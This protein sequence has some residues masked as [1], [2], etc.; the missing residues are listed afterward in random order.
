MRLDPG[1][2]MEAKDFLGK[3]LTNQLVIKTLEVS[4]PKDTEWPVSLIPALKNIEEVILWGDI[5]D[6]VKRKLLETIVDADRASLK[7]R[8][9]RGLSTLNMDEK[10][11]A[12]AAIRLEALDA[13]WIF[14]CDQ[15]RPEGKPKKN[16][17]LTFMN[18]GN[19]KY[20][21][22]PFPQSGFVKFG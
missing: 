5:E 3:I 12:R 9:L 2:A 22:H 15:V 10:L 4:A 8:R 11:V 13:H 17:I 18:K 6:C 14:T 1:N 7:L 20:I 21:F 19:I 16:K